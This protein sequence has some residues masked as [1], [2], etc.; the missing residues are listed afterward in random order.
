MTRVV[1]RGR[2]R[3]HV[4]RRAHRG[5]PAADRADAALAPAVAGKR[6]DADQGRDGRDATG[7]PSSGRCAIKAR[8]VCG[9]DARHRPQ[10]VLARLPDGTLANGRRDVVIQRGQ[11]PLE[12]RDVGLQRFAHGRPRQPQAIA[13]GPSISTSCRRRV[14]CA[15]RSCVAAS[16]SGRT[17]AGPA[18]QT[19]PAGARRAGRSWPVGPAPAQNRGPGAG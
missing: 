12:P 3:G 8:A 15:S 11:L 19:G 2:E 14:T 17:G 13:F 18:R 7:G 6:G 10:Q 5:A 4:E 9:P 16:A 1:A